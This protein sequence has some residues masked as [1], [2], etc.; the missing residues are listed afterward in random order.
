MI[1]IKKTI[2]ETDLMVQQLQSSISVVKGQD[3]NQY[4]MVVI[5]GPSG[6]TALTLDMIL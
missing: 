3:K 4:R 2:R 5:F 1:I 6:A